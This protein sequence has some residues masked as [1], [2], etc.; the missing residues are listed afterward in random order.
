MDALRLRTD[1][2]ELT[3]STRGAAVL[4]WETDTSTGRRSLLRPARHHGNGAPDGTAAFPLVPFGNPVGGNAFSFADLNHHLRANAGDG[5]LSDW[6]IEAIDDNSA[7]L[8]LRHAADTT[9]RW[10]YL[11]RQTAT[12]DG[13]RLVLTLSVEN[14]GRDALPFGLG[15]RPC[16]PLTSRTRLMAPASSVWLEGADH[17][18]TEEVPLPADFDFRRAAP[19]PDRRANN[20]FEG[21]NG[22][23]RIDW[24][25]HGLT[26]RIDADPIFSRYVIYRP[27][28]VRDPAY[29][30]DW[31]CFEPMTHA[32]DDF[33]MVGLGGLTPLQPGE[34]FEGRISL[35]ALIC[36]LPT[37]TGSA[38][39]S[40]SRNG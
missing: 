26:L 40:G 19:L 3:L 17:L 25:E 20:A 13:R 24:P 37:W 11:A 10:D 14:K 7:T 34:R 1:V 4:G 23:A 22:C 8:A 30:G 27:D 2:A 21:W 6:T 38:D 29:T 35:E 9:A 28:A 5:R 39:L 32:A 18:R 33:R 12:L 16:F 36:P 15:W 31:F